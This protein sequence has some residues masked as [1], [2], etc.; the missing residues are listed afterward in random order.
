MDMILWRMR[1]RHAEILR[2]TQ[3]DGH[4]GNGYR[5]TLWVVPLRTKQ[6]KDASPIPGVGLEEEIEFTGGVR[7][8]REP[9]VEIRAVMKQLACRMAVLATQKAQ[10]LASLLLAERQHLVEFC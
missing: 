7:P 9:S 5:G 3:H 2:P 6:L 10:Q 4:P 1:A 8:A